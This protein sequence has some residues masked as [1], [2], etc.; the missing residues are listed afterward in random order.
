MT[1]ITA[2][3]TIV[4]GACVKIKRDRIAGIAIVC[5]V[6][7]YSIS[8][9]ILSSKDHTFTSC[10]FDDIL[11]VFRGCLANNSKQNLQ[12]GLH[13]REHPLSGFSGWTR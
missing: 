10:T 7:N 9:K 5:V 1:V 8:V 3:I 12:R 6:V 2:I 4:A 13:S 11:V